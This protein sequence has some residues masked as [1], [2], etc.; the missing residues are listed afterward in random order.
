MEMTMTFILRATG[1]KS[2][3]SLDQEVLVIMMERYN[4][5]L[6]P[7]MENFSFLMNAAMRHIF[8]DGCLMMIQTA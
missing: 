8:Q 6:L 7:M 4:L 1:R 2:H 5:N 3:R